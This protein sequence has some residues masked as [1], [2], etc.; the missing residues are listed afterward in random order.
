MKLNAILALPLVY[1][2][3]SYAAVGGRCAGTWGPQCI[4]LDWRECESRGGYSAEGTPG[5]YPLPQRPEQCH[6]VLHPG[7]RVGEHVLHLAG[8]VFWAD[9]QR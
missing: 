5:D 6:G 8:R 4:C 1:L 7:L 3:L 9:S 2:P